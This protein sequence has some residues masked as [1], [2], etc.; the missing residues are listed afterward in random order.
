MAAI[1]LATISLGHTVSGLPATRA[2]D[3]VYE[4]QEVYIAQYV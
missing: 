2:R 1:A 3:R 4:A